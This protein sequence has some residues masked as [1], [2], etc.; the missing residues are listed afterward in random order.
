M[1]ST[2]NQAIKQR[3]TA[4]QQLAELQEKHE[5]LKAK[6]HVWRREL[7]AAN[8]RLYIKNLELGALQTR[9][10][11]SEEN[12]LLRDHISALQAVV[13]NHSLAGLVK[14]GQ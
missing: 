10:E 1:K 6:A 11:L 4:E 2:I 13:I 8:R 14:A 9:K 7:R 5:A 3:L 12:E